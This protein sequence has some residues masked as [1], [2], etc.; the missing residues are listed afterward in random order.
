MK[1]NSPFKVRTLGLAVAAVLVTGTFCATSYA[2]TSL[3]AD[4]AVSATVVSTCS[5]STSPV[6]MGSV[7]QFNISTLTGTG[8]LHVLCTNGAPGVITLNDGSHADVSSAADV[9]L[10]AMVNAKGDLLKYSITQDGASAIWGF[11]NATSLAYTG[12][13]STENK[14][15]YVSIAQGQNAPVGVYSDTVVATITF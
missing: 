15:V 8:A 7:D 12:T 1:K 2:T 6:V 3:T 10:R 14:S 9:P 13:G 4:L 11:G 5:I